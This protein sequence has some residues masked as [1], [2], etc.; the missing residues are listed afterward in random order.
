MNTKELL[1][2]TIKHEYVPYVPMMYRGDPVVNERLINHFKLGSIEKDW[3]KL[4]NMLGADNFSDGETLGAFS[5]YIPKYVGPDFNTVYEINNFRIWGIRPVEI[6]VA[7]TVDI[8]FHNDPPLYNL[9]S[10]S[11]IANYKYRFPISE[12][13]NNEQ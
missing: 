12:K 1:V 2:S 11:D 3:E 4:I 5:I 10:V 8:V 9:D 7:G 13:R 6:E